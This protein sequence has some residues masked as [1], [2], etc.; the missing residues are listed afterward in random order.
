MR[1]IILTGYRGTG[2]STVAELVA[3]ALDMPVV[4]MDAELMARMGR[5]IPEFVAVNGWPAF[6]ELERSLMIELADQDGL[7]IDTGGGA[8]MHQSEMTRLR[9]GGA[10]FWLTA[11]P[12]RI[13]ERLGGDVSRPALNTGKTFL[14]EIEEVLR[15]RAP[16]Y[17]LADHQ[18]DTDDRN[19]ED[20]ARDI[21][22]FARRRAL[23]R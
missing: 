14:E 3:A 13:R 5:G 15:E 1:H 6:R 10:V 20:I 8:V 21:V 4:H 19:P 7:V 16:L 18:V 11:S 22:D 23:A 2:K 17:A 9:M 12:E